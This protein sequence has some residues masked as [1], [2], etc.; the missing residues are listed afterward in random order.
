V[1]LEIG[2]DPKLGKEIGETGTD[3]AMIGVCDIGALDA[4]LAQDS[5]DAVDEAIHAQVKKGFGIV[6]VTGRPGAVM[7]CV[8]TGSD[9][10]G[11]VYVLMA[12]GR[13]I[14]FQLAFIDE[15][16]IAGEPEGGTPG[17]SLLGQDRDDFKTWALAGGG[18]F[19]CWLGGKLKAGADIHIWSD[20]PSSSVAYRVRR[21]TQRLK[22][23]WTPMARVRGGGARFGAVEVLGAG[24]YD[25]D[26]QIGQEVF[27]AITLVLKKPVKRAGPGTNR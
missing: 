19:S 16:G 13:R 8:P 3:S 18:E 27:S 23:N 4:A 1:R 15:D 5:P 22:K 17:V 2:R 14:G 26:F 21:G 6:K 25:I 9:G 11:P 24:R 7:P 20:A 12:G 10:S